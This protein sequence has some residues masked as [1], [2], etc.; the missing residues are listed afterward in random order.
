MIHEDP[1]GESILGQEERLG[2]ALKQEHTCHVWGIARKP[3]YME[4]SKGQEGRKVHSTGEQGCCEGLCNPLHGLILSECLRPLEGFEQRT[5]MIWL[6][7]SCCI[8]YRPMGRWWWMQGGGCGNNHDTSHSS[9]DQGSIA[10]VEREVV[11]SWKCFG[12]SIWGFA[13]RLSLFMIQEWLQ[14]FCL[15]GQLEG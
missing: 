9:L 5:D 2:K 10:A 14:M 6:T 3:V 13:N 12:G 8:E 15:D 11:R 4:Q 1:W 7:F